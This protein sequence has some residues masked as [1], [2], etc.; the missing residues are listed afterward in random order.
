MEH[1]LRI[2]VVLPLYGDMKPEL[3]QKLLEVR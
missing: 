2:L 3:R 1:P